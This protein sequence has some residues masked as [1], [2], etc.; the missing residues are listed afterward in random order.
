MCRGESY[1]KEGGELQKM[2]QNFE[3]MIIIIM[4]IIIKKNNLYYVI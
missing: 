2:L 4:V 1:S 3:I